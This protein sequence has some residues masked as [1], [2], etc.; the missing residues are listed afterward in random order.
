MNKNESS[1]TSLNEKNIIESKDKIENKLE[2]K[3]K[4]SSPIFPNIIYPQNKDEELD[5]IDNLRYKEDINNNCNIKNRLD[6]VDSPIKAQFKFSID[7]PNVSKQRLHEYLTDDL[8]NALEVSPNIPNLNN[9]IENI[10]INEKNNIN[11]NP[12]SLFGFS[13]YNSN[14]DN[15]LENKNNEDLKNNSDFNINEN[16]ELLSKNNI[17]NISNINNIKNVNDSNNNYNNIHNDINKITKNLTIDNIP[18]YIPKQ[19]RNKEDIK[20]YKKKKS[21]KDENKISNNKFDNIKKNNV[22]KKEGKLKKPFEVRAGDWICNKCTNLNFAFRN[23]CNRCGLTKVMSNQQNLNKKEI[24]T[25]NTNFQMIEGFNPN[26]IH[27]N[28]VKNIEE[29]K[30]YQK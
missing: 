25:Q 15:N 2:N 26:F 10:K 18:T 14:N 6:S 21:E 11:N 12:N 22:F 27:D 4:D 28:N 7:M 29:T 24:Y 9:G 30:F 8:L 23:K 1:L 20:N 5:D 19:M 17:N 13:L 3:I 16:N